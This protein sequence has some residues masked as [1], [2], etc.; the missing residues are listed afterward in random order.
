M[1]ET[2]ARFQ[3]CLLAFQNHKFSNR[4]PFANPLKDLIQLER[5][6]WFENLKRQRQEKKG[7][8]ESSQP[9]QSLLDWEQF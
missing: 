6:G 3:F 8:G 5:K 4:S 7:G 9:H 1:S 2:D